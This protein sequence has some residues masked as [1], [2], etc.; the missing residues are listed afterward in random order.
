MIAGGEMCG[1]ELSPLEHAEE[2][3]RIAETLVPATPFLRESCRKVA[4]QFR[5]E[6][7]T[8][9]RHC[10]CCLVPCDKCRRR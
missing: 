10:G 7:E 3:E 6:H 1:D 5:L 8:G 9:I 4:W 2:W